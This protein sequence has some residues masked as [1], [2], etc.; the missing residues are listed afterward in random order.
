M[1]PPPP[2][3]VLSFLIAVKSGKSGVFILEFSFV[4]WMVTILGF[5]EVISSSS[6]LVLFLIPFILIYNIL[7]SLGLGSWG[8]RSL[9]VEEE[10]W[11]GEGG[12]WEEWDEGDEEEDGV[13]ERDDESAVEWCGLSD[14]LDRLGELWLS[15]SVAVEVEVL[16]L[17]EDRSVS[18]WREQEK[19]E[20]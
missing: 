15:V 7:K 2:S 3:V 8:V 17:S 14:V 19:D 12:E 16:G 20:L 11:E 6:S 1:S 10:E 18:W 4:S 13:E 9:S 5:E